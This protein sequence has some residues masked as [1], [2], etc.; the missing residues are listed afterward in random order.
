MTTSKKPN[1][2]ILWGDD[3]G[4]WNISYNSRGQ[5]GYRTPNIDRVANEGV[6]FTDY[7]GQQ[8]C[9]AGRAAFITGQNPIRS[10]LTKV[11]MPGADLG[12][13]K[14]DPT[15]AELLKPLGYATGQFGKNHL[16]DRNEFLPTMHGFDEFFG[17]LYH[18]NAEEEPED[19][20]YPKDPAF[21]QRFG[22]RGVIHSWADGQGG[23]KVEDT[24]PLTKKRM[25]T[26]DEEVTEHALRFI[27]QCHQ[28]GKPFF[29]WYNTTAMHFRTHCPDKHKGKSGQGDYN[30]VM[31]AH[32][33]LIGRML[34]KLDEL[35]I[36]DDTIVM[37]STDN[38]VHYN[39]WPDA[40]ITPF[41]SE[42]N[43][44]W[45]GGWR[46]PA[47]IRWPS[48]FPAGTVVNGIVSHQDWLPTLLAA[49]GEPEIKEKLLQGHTIGDR[50]YKVHID[51]FNMLPYLSGEVTD[52]PRNAIFYFSDDGDLIAIRH[53]DWKMVLMEQRAK[54]LQCWFEPFVPLRAP[55]MFNLRRDPFERADENSNTY[56][57]WVI[58]HAY[59]VYA[60]QGLVAQQIEAFVQFP[61]RQ[62][63]ASFNL[64]AV[65]R[66]LEDAASSRN[67]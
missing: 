15:I 55:K 35:G 56:W 19:P 57:D 42:K 20:D 28:D 66:Q 26:I 43:T 6:A 58:S 67:H 3:I 46:I 52:S 54:T 61:P 48:Q 8:S 60:M 41:R 34:D 40:G 39:T 63:P 5:M 59:L 38:G 11:G 36:A 13:Q 51:G 62:K 53:G 18:L 1:I 16:G 24:G 45:E 49:A 23:Q 64:D 25:E 2:L 31:V 32:D 14:E 37:Y 29:M 50:T 21:K 27:D 33:E 22:P 65:M 10:G 17:N 44:N 9:T 47:F 7:Y 30:D 12:L 4:W